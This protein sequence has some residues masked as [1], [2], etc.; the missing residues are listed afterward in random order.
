MQIIER[1]SVADSKHIPLQLGTG[2]EYQRPTPVAWQRELDALCPPSDNLPRFLLRWE[3]GESWEPIGRWVIWNLMPRHVT[4]ETGRNPFYDAIV[5]ECEGPHPR[6]TGH[7]CAPN[8]C[9]C[10]LK[11]GS[12]RGGTTRIIDRD[13]WEVYQQTGRYGRRWWVIQG[14]NGGHRYRLAEWERTIWRTVTH[15]GDVPVLGE[16]PYAPWDNRVR[17]HLLGLE[18]TMRWLGV[19]RYGEKNRHRLDTD[20]KAE[21]EMAKSAVG[22]WMARQMDETWDEYGTLLK[23]HARSVGSGAYLPDPHFNPDEVAQS[24]HLS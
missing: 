20:E 8:H 4:H 18:R 12:W 21:I 10:E 13:T 6:S 23:R 22:D 11:T 17:R 1:R 7:Y 24:Y 15:T 16:L 2:V 14:S 19:V 9:T 5:A 3:A